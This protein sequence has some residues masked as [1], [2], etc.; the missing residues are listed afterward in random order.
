MVALSSFLH[1]LIIVI[2][3]IKV[4]FVKYAG[5]SKRRGKFH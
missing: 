3:I 1:E 2:L 4:C 5:C